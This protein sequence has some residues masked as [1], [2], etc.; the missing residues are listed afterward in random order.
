MS[1]GQVIKKLR[2][3]RNLTQEELA[4]LL[5]VTS[6]AV[7]KWENGA[8][9]PDISQI[10]P[11]ASVFGV[12]TDV[13]F[14][15]FGTSDDEEVRKILDNA[16]SLNDDKEVDAKRGWTVLQDGLK[17]YPNHLWLLVNCLERGN[18]LCY[19][20]GY[21]ETH[22]EE[23]FPECIRMANI[24]IAYSKHATDALRAHMIMVT[25]CTAYGNKEK[26]REHAEKFP[27]RADMTAHVMSAYVAHFEKDYAKEAL[28]C[29]RDIMYH[30]EAMLCDIA[31]LGEAYR[32]MKQY[33]DAL[34][35]FHSVFALIKIIFADEKFMPP[36][37][38]RERGDVHV[39][40]ARTYLEM[41][42]KSKALDW[43]EKMV[44]YDIDVLDKSK[45]DM[46]IKTPSLRDV[47]YDFYFTWEPLE[48]WQKRLL[49]KLNSEDFESLRTDA[50]FTA[51]L[52]RANDMA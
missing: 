36:I 27:W 34:K 5:N 25:L 17:K 6:Q 41:D 11:I 30:L 33:D 14:G 51:L 18:A 2:K 31:Q 50:R 49:K 43:L 47:E 45:N 46:Y 39:L 8:G 48:H 20:S 29:Q 1:I 24:I 15:T 52:E 22:R 28:H 44:D 7:S 42:D 13:L 3:E 19:I 9:L 40:I 12:S 26:A 35:M 21:D 16:Y 10:V 38:R 37:H 23:I 4:E 32:Y